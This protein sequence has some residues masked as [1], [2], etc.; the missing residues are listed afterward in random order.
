MYSNTDLEPGDHSI[1]IEAVK[2][3]GEP[4]ETEVLREQ[5]DIDG[6]YIYKKLNPATDRKF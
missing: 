5:I 1:T 6:F 3:V 2:T 4:G